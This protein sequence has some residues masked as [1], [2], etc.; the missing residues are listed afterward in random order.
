[1][2]Q[3]SLFNE[4]EK[5]ADNPVIKGSIASPS[6]IAYIMSQK[7]V[8]A[9][10]LYRQEKEFERLGINISRQNMANWVI[11]SAHDWLEPLYSAMKE[12]EYADRFSRGHRA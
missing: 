10:P 9:M 7:F 3:L 8:N 1:M 2:I 12:T 4:A 11:R 5:D 6:I